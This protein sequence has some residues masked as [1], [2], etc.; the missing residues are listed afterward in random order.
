MKKINILLKISLILLSACTVE[1][2]T[3][4][5]F[6][7][8]AS[9]EV[10]QTPISSLN[11]IDI[12][13]VPLITNSNYNMSEILEIEV[14]DSNFYVHER[15]SNSNIF[16]F[17]KN[18]HFVCQIGKRGKG[19][20]EYLFC[21][22]LAVSSKN[23]DIFI[24]SGSENKIY[25]YSSNGDFIRTMKVHSSK[26]SS[27]YCLD[28][29]IIYY[30]RNVDG[31]VKNSFELINSNA[32]KISEH[33]NKYPYV[34]KHCVNG[35]SNECIF[36]MF[37]DQLLSKEIYSDTIFYFDGQDF[38]PKYILDFGAKT[39]PSE[40]RSTNDI[41]GFLNNSSKYVNQKNLFESYYYIFFE[42]YLNNR[43]Y[44]CICSKKDKSVFFINSEKGFINDIDGGPRI[45]P[46][47]IMNDNTIISWIYPYQLKSHVASEAFRNSKPK[48]PEKKKKLE[49]LAN[50]LDEN[51]NPVL[52]LVN[53]KE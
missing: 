23:Q 6:D 27:L 51:D 1:K 41:F 46:K 40:I 24:L 22:D 32:E 29:K 28:D 18:G 38:I 37:K 43:N 33:S 12:S 42:F 39:M 7:L 5:I 31:S 8:Q 16:K 30:N 36:Y 4:S 13:Y 53:L 25:I 50:S 10:L 48:Y 26:S 44:C 19:P 52:M 47:A 17:S 34:S 45:S 35:F 9:V 11:I 49:E 21:S 3:L 20:Q 14:F 15:G 2:S